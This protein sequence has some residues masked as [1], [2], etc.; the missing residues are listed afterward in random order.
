MAQLA[1]QDPTAPQDSSAFVAQLA[2]FANVELAQNQNSQL[3]ALLV[4]QAANNQTTV[5]TLV[6]KEVLFQAEELTVT[7]ER[8]PEIVLDLASRAQSVSVTLLDENGRIVS[9]RT[10]QNVSAGRTT[11]DPVSANGQPLPP[12]TY[13]IEIEADDGR[14]NAIDVVQ[15]IRGHV[16]GVSFAQGY[17]QLLVGDALLSLADVI[18]VHEGNG[19]AVAFGAPSTS[20][21]TITG[22]MTGGSSLPFPYQGTRGN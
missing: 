22:Q 13:T 16:E 9:E 1:Y 3:E 20:N 12:G 21:E 7:A 17:P 5:T 6:G 10:L 11:V 8:T 18:E 15:G 19:A 4:A 14:G 2:Q